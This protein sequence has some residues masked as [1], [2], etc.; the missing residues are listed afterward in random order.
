M[1]GIMAFYAFL[2]HPNDFGFSLSFSPALFFYTDSEI[3][4]FVDDVGS[5]A[6][7]YISLKGFVE[8]VLE[9]F[10]LLVALFEVNVVVGRIC[11]H[12]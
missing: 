4:Q 11:L 3:S 7:G 10:H 5:I 6:V 8:C 2:S 1:G 9:G 12:Q